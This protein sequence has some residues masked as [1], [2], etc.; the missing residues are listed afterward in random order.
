[1]AENKGNDWKSQRPKSGSSTEAWKNWAKANPNRAS[2]A[3]KAEAETNPKSPNFKATTTSSKTGSKARKEAVAKWQKARPVS[4]RGASMSDAE[5]EER[6][7][8]MKNW[9]KWNPNKRSNAQRAIK[10]TKK[11]K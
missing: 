6:R 1:M 8:A 11:K 2:Q 5:K 7:N 4:G 9:A 3:K 10:E